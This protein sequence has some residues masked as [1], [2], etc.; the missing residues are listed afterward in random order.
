M[1]PELAERILKASLA[2]IDKEV[3]P[4]MAESV[5]ESSEVSRDAFQL[6]DRV[7]S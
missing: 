6:R 5:K 1:F 7:V 3:L 2:C 4:L